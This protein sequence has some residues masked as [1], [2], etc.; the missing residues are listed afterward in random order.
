[1]NIVAVSLWHEV[2][3]TTYS[4]GG[5]ILLLAQK[6]PEVLDRVHRGTGSLLTYAGEWH[7]HPMGGSDL[8]DTDKNAVI[9]LRSILDHVDL[10]TLV[11]IVT[12]AEIRPHLFEPT[13]PAVTVEPPRRGFVG[14][15]RAK[16]GWKLR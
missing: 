16:L 5:L 13:S 9:S 4:A 10:P 8:S 11:M 14:F 1:V 12:P 3:A 6:L 15:V 2:A 7:T